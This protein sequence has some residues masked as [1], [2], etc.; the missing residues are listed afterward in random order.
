LVQFPK[1][2]RAA[3]LIFTSL[4]AFSRGLNVA[5]LGNHN[6]SAWGTNCTASDAAFTE[7]NLSLFG[8]AAAQAGDLR[9][10]LLVFPEGYS[11]ARL[12]KGAQFE[13]LVS[14]V[15][16]AAPCD[17]PAAAGAPQQAALSC[18]ARAHRFVIAA[19]VFVSLANGSS[20]IAELVFDPTGAAVSVYFKHH[21]FPNE[22]AAGVS[23]GPFAPTV[24]P[25]LGRVWGVI[26]CYEGVYPFLTGDFSQMDALK[27]A[28]AD[29]FV[30]SVGGEAP[31]DALS[32][33][34]AEK[35][36]V[37]VV[38]AMDASVEASGGAIYNSSGAPLPYH[39]ARVRVGGGYTGAA[40]LR[41]AVIA[42]R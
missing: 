6:P 37:D 5:V 9:A 10:D 33:A 22:V 41:T 34:L 35:Y 40:T 14:S 12:Y 42:G 28:G 19:N 21:L 29:A 38:A 8:A 20:R 15:G 3:H 31:L 25:A 30:W 39:D 11:L 18:L 4:F 32:A 36:K 7:C 26:I 23:A 27:A 24:F 1:M 2:M 13:S 17:A 16:G